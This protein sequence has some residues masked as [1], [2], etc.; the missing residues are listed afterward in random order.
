MKFILGEKPLAKIK[1]EITRKQRRA[2]YQFVL[3]IYT[4]DIET[5][6]VKY[7]KLSVDDLNDLKYYGFCTMIYEYFGLAYGNYDMSFKFPE[8]YKHKPVI[9]KG[10]WW[11]DLGG[12]QTERIEITKKIL[13]TL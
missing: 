3:N 12:E 9:T 7:R 5:L 1:D 2:F 4:L 11:F 13:A 6:K 8:L 10:A